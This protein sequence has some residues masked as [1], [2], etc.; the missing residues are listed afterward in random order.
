MNDN[1]IPPKGYVYVEGEVHLDNENYSA[2]LFYDGKVKAWL[3]ESQIED[4]EELDN[5]RVELLIP[6][7]LAADRGLI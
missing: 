6:E 7:W 3:P 5:G 1:R 2:V 4:R